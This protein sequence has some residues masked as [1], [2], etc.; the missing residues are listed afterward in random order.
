[1]QDLPFVGRDNELSALHDLT[2][3]RVSSLAV[4]KGRRRIGKSRLVEE[5]AQKSNYKFLKFSGIPPHSQ[6]TA[7]SERDVFVQQLS[8]T[9]N[10]PQVSANDWSNLFT[11]LARETRVGKYVILFDEI[12]WMGSKDHDFLGKL[13]T[14]WDF[15]LKKNPK[16]ILLLCGSVS[17]WIENNI[18]ASTGF[19][20]RLSLVLDLKELH[21]IECNQLLN[22]VGFP[23]IAYER[24]KILSVTGGIPRYLEEIKSDRLADENIKNLC[25]TQD[26]VLF[27]EFNDIFID[28]FAKRST[29]Y[30]QIVT[31]LVDGDKEFDA[32]TAATKIGNNGHLSEH[33]NNLIKSGFISRDYTWKIKDGIQSTLSRY[34]LSDNYLRF[35]LKYIHK[36]QAKIIN[37]HFNN[38]SLTVLPGWQSIMGLQFE[39]LVLNNREFIWKKLN[40]YPE[41]IIVDNPYF[42]RQQIRANGCQIDYLIQTR[43]N[44]LYACE[45]KFLKHPVSLGIMKSVQ[46]KLTAFSL[47][48]GFSILPVLIHVGGV[49]DSVIDESYFSHIIDFTEIFSG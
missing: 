19:V 15:E 34:R 8:I 48:R 4:I 37:Q 13:K 36:N 32:I 16:L 25:F 42:Q 26:G 46:Q 39:N 40:I 21:A 5:F 30:Q 18:L 23:K 44:I 9:L 6:T 29:L 43:M 24:F 47:P 49:D 27:R 41:D 38:T 14:I 10:L 22:H 28:I 2:K 12:S 3:K 31:A 7:Q 17:S 45:I 20:G 11:F 35:Y 33:L 1:M